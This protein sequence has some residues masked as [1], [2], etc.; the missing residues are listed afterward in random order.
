MSKQL[1]R[2]IIEKI[3]LAN[4]FAY[5]AETLNIEVEEWLEKNGIE[6]GF[7]ATFDFREDHGYVIEP[8]S[9]QRILDQVED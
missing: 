5:R 1:P 9:V 4:K 3:N 7:E 6:D 8:E 2:Y